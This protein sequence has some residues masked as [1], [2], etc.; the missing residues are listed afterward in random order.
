MG[1]IITISCEPASELFHED[2]SRRG[3][4]KGQMLKN[5]LECHRHRSHNP[6]PGGPFEGREAQCSAVQ[7]RVIQRLDPGAA[8][9]TIADDR[10]AGI[11]ELAPGLVLSPGHQLQF[12]Q[13]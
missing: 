9:A 13:S 12:E 11:G 6:V 1:I 8:V 5:G 7:P 2:I 10:P 3:Q 4:V